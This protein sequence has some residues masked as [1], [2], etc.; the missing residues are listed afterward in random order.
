MT[1]TLKSDLRR[2]AEQR[3]KAL[4]IVHYIIGALD[5]M[6]PH[7]LQMLQRMEQLL[8]FPDAS[9]F[10]K[11]I[12]LQESTGTTAAGPENHTPQ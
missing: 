11:I 2:E 12:K 3:R 8:P 4:E 5:D 7:S 9:E 10:L 1:P 6:E